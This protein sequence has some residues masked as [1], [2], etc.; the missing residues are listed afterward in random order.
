MERVEGRSGADRNVKESAS[1][2]ICFHTELFT[3]HSLIFT[4]Q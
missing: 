1:S 4:E 2:E 3:H